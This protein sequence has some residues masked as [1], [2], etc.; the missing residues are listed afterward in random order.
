MIILAPLWMDPTMSMLDPE[1]WGSFESLI[2]ANY[3]EYLGRMFDELMADCGA[4]TDAYQQYI[5]VLTPNAQALPYDINTSQ[6]GR[7]Q[8]LL[9]TTANRTLMIP[10]DRTIIGNGIG[11]DTYN[12]VAVDP[13]TAEDVTQDVFNLL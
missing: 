10:F 3:E 4:F 5:N 12:I 11:G 2:Q 1:I 9:D 8:R 13:T 7:V 6:V